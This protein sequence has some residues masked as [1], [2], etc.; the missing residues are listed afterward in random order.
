MQQVFAI[1][2]VRDDSNKMTSLNERTWFM[3]LVCVVRVFCV[4]LHWVTINLSVITWVRSITIPKRY[5][6]QKTHYITRFAR[7]HWLSCFAFW[8]W[9]MWVKCK[10]S[11]I[12]LKSLR[13]FQNKQTLMHTLFGPMH[14]RNITIIRRIRSFM[15]VCY[16]NSYIVDTYFLSTNT[17]ISVRAQFTVMWF[18]LVLSF[19]L[20]IPDIHIIDFMCALWFV[21]VELYSFASHE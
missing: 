17:R 19:V 10:L 1:A 21:S 4:R 2:S 12:V 11:C 14:L 15:Y 6:K 13:R 18:L 9:E 16:A 7:L 5:T 20:S 8:Q 3:I